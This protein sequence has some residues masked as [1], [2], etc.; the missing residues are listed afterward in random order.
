MSK[1]EECEIIKDLT[2]Q[3]IDN[4]LKKKKKKFVSEHLEKC[5]D[6]KE[7]Y[8]KI[9]VSIFSENEKEKNNDTILVN[10]FKKIHNHINSLKISILLIILLIIGILLFVFI[11]QYNFSNIV[12]NAYEK[13]EYMKTLDNYKLTIK[14][15]DKNFK[16]NTSMEYEE[17]T[18]YKG[19]K[20][21]IQS[22]DS[23]KFY[24]DDS[25]EKICVY[26]DLETK[27]YYKQDFIEMTKGKT[28]N[29]FSEII[30]YQKLTWSISSLAFSVRTESFNGISCYVIR[31][32][33][34]NSYRD[35]WI[36]KNTF[37]TLRVV[38]EN[39]NDFYREEI[40]KFEENSVK[41]EDVNSAI[42]NSAPYNNY[43]VKNIINNA[44][45]EIKTY[46]YLYN[47]YQKTIKC[48]RI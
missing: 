19:G 40:F 23:L 35:T 6:C 27:E 48:F 21:K 32:G 28:I 36:D 34:N 13:I 7:Y 20:Y 2:P 44:T 22:K 37:L 42:L 4:L 43:T 33:N 5:S 16:N 12:N 14:T 39:K 3:Y 26:N 29:I 1:K 46:N 47:K 31:F 18:Y 11:K 8:T 17:T 24:Q 45:D 41:D 15:I 9:K 10:Q 38:N 25:Y 30:N